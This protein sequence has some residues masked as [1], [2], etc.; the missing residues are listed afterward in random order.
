MQVVSGVMAELRLG[1]S[2]LP[3]CGVAFRCI[4]FI[5]VLSSNCVFIRP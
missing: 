5:S 1:V 3:A 2:W 4:V